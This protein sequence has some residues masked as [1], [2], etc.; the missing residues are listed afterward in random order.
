MNN[1]V[2]EKKSS[3]KNLPIIKLESKATLKVTREFNSL[4]QYLC[5]RISDV[6]WSGVLFFESSGE[7]NSEEG[8]TITP[9]DIYPMDIGSS[10]YTEY[11]FSEEV[12]DY[13]EHHA[14]RFGMKYGHIHSHNSM[15]TWFSGT[16]VQELVDNCVNHSFYVS[17]IVNNKNDMVARIAIPGKR[18]V[19]SDSVYSFSGILG[20]ILNIPKKSDTE[21]DVMYYIEM[22]IEREEQVGDKFFFDRVDKIINDHRRPTWTNKSSYGDIGQFPS[23]NRINGFQKPDAVQRK[24]VL[25][26][27]P[28]ISDLYP[29]PKLFLE[30]LGGKDEPLPDVFDDIN[31]VEVDKKEK[32]F[33]LEQ[34][35]DL[36]AVIEIMQSYQRDY[37]K[38]PGLKEV[39]FVMN[40]F[41]G[42]CNYYINFNNGKYADIARNISSVI[43]NQLNEIQYEESSV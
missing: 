2:K 14:E 15:G 39:I 28:D 29:I 22:D 1:F 6:E 43:D 9:V 34:C 30:L 7:V 24:I 25:P 17:L 31:K 3:S 38:Q 12:F 11:D 42:I 20:T 4:V 13:Y 40:R 23:H 8:V 10:A 5:S 37:Q 33:Y 16:D 35:F 26:E 41:K 19:S 21:E 18:K 36:D 27:E 32:E